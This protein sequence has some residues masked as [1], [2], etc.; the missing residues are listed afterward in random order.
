MACV[1][2]VKYLALQKQGPRP[3]GTLENIWKD[4]EQ[5]ELGR[6]GGLWYCPTAAPWHPRD[7]PAAGVTYKPE[8]ELL[9]PQQEPSLGGELCEGSSEEAFLSLGTGQG[10]LD[11]AKP[12]RAA[13]MPAPHQQQH[14]DRQGPSAPLVSPLTPGWEHTRQGA[15][16]GR[17]PSTALEQSS[18]RD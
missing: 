12:P 9:H 1:I 18:R 17:N 14:Q 7:S 6:Q 2:V 16:A 5:P 4:T 3:T 11:P 10:V 13:P 8:Q 15:D